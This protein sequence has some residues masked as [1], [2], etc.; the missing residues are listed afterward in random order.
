[1]TQNGL[2]E[3]ACCGERWQTIL[4]S[5]LP[6]GLYYLHVLTDKAIITRKR[7]AIKK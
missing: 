5:D 6:E 2:G 7:I 4:V 3:E 1:M